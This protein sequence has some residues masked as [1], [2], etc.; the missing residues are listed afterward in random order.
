MSKKSVQTFLEQTRNGN[1]STNRHIVYAALKKFEHGADLD[2]LRDYCPYMPHQ[3]LTAALSVLNDWGVIHQGAGG[4]YYITAHGKEEYIA[5]VREMER[6]K[7][8]KKAGERNGW[9]ERQFVED[10]D[11]EYHKACRVGENGQL[12]LVQPE[13]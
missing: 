9:F 3:S 13:D 5:A 7:R 12:E 8:W 11:A 6:Y 1:L 2:T 10:M 4:T